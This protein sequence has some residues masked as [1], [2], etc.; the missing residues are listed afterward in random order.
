MTIR[1]DN[2]DM[3]LT[4]KGESIIFRLLSSRTVLTSLSDVQSVGYEAGVVSEQRWQAFQQTRHTMQDLLKL[5]HSTSLN[6]QVRTHF[7]FRS[8]LVYLWEKIMIIATLGL[9]RSRIYRTARRCMEKVRCIS[10]LP[11]RSLGYRFI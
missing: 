9:G 7:A 1:S 5:L 6:P 8:Q 4:E 3:R 2:A 10:K 11:P